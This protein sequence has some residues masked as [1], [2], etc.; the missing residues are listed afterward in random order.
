MKPARYIFQFF[1]VAL[2]LSI[3]IAGSVKTA[4][5]Y[6]FIKDKYNHPPDTNPPD[7]TPLPYPFGDNNGNPYDD[8]QHN[9]AAAGAGAMRRAGRAPVSDPGSWTGSLWCG[10]CAGC[11]RT[12]AGRSVRRSG[13]GP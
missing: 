12:H 5:D 9:G 7:T 1:A 3:A 10:R 13:P 6:N 11:R 2:I 4:P 8:H